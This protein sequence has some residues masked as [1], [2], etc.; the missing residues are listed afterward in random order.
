MCVR[1]CV[2]TGLR[3]TGGPYLTLQGS[4]DN[5]ASSWR[6]GIEEGKDVGLA[7]VGFR[8]ALELFVVAQRLDKQQPLKSTVLHL[9]KC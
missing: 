9:I 4:L 3:D 8:L 5:F 2:P 1:L 7:W 6:G